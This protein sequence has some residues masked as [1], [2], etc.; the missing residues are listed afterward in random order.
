MTLH[1]FDGF[2]YFPTVDQTVIQRNFQADGWFLSGGSLSVWADTAFGYGLCA[3]WEGI[4]FGENAVRSFNGNLYSGEQVVGFRMKT[5]PTSTATLAFQNNMSTQLNQFSIQFGPD[6]SMRVFNGDGTLVT[7]CPAG[8]LYPNSWVFMEFKFTIGSSALFE[9]RA[10]TKVVLSV[11][12]INL[13]YGVPLLG[14]DYGYDAMSHTLNGGGGGIG[15]T[16]VWD[17]YYALDTEG[18]EHNDYLGNVR[19]VFQE[20]VGPGDLTNWNIGG[21]APAATNWQ[22]VLNKN[23][24]GTKFVYEGTTN[25]RDLYEMSASVASPTIEAMMV[26]GA[27]RLDDATQKKVKNT[28]RTG[29]GTDAVGVDIFPDQTYRYYFDIFITNPDTGVAWTD[30]EINTVQI[31]PKIVA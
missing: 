19:T 22:S 28:L 25:D 8:T 29:L 24:D 15:T 6:G 27:Y 13:G 11:P 12:S 26:K 10:N 5:G 18:S 16:W 2:D 1:I 3:G 4:S 30:A 20:A 7:G 21:S 14:Y 31:G 23:L 9:V 17:D